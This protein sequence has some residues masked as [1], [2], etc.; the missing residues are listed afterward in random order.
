MLIEGKIRQVKLQNRGEKS[1]VTCFAHY[2]NLLLVGS[3]SFKGE[4]GAWLY[5]IDRLDGEP[6]KLAIPSV[7]T[8]ETVALN[9]QFAAVGQI[10]DS[11]GTFRLT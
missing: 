9:E 11:S 5:D 1:F 6:E 10:G 3:L 8:G 4:S 7:Y 2:K